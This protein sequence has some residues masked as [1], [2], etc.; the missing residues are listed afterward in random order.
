MSDAATRA[1]QARLHP[2]TQ[3]G[4]A[5]TMRARSLPETLAARDRERARMARLVRWLRDA[6]VDADFATP[7]RADA[8]RMAASGRA[9]AVTA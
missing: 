4:G 3:Q 1:A 5:L 2:P 6:S 7:D 8:E 9:K